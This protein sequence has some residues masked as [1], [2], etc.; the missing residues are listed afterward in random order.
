LRDVVALWQNNIQH[1]RLSGAPVR[2][3]ANNRIS[4]KQS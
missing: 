1:R 2:R 4:N 3:P